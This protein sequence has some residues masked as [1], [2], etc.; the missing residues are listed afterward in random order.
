MDSGSESSKMKNAAM[1]WR[2][3][4]RSK[5]GELGSKYF[6]GERLQIHDKRQEIQ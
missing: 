1:S 5:K 2:S 4:V 3:H 6:I